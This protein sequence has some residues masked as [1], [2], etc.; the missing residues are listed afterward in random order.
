MISKIV[1]DIEDDYDKLYDN[2]EMLNKSTSY[3][4]ENII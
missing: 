2:A 3:L 1:I 4:S